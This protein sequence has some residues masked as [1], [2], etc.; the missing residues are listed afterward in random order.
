M[1]TQTNPTPVVDPNAVPGVI[2][3]TPVP[4]TEEPAVPSIP[5]EP[6]VEVPGEVPTGE[7]VLEEDKPTDTPAAPAV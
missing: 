2:P 5:G 1:D 7:P 4:A 6:V 3:P